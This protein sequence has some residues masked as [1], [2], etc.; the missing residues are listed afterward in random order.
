M[1]SDGSKKNDRFDEVRKKLLDNSRELNGRG[2]ELTK[3]KRSGRPPKR[4]ARLGDTIIQNSV[5]VFNQVSDP[6]DGGTDLK[7]LLVRILDRF[8]PGSV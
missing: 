6:R 1:S 4:A 5:I 3:G 8:E 7:D 2:R